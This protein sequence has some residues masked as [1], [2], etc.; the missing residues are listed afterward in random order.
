MSQVTVTRRLRFSAAHRLHHPALSPEE[1]RTLFSRDNNPHGHGHNYTLEVSVTGE[2]D[3]R[4]GYVIDLGELRRVAEEAIIEQ[5]D[6]QFEPQI[7]F[8]GGLA[9]LI[10]FQRV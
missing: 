6:Q 10:N 5:L 8:E 7:G 9:Q 1:N 3:D 4:T 2:I